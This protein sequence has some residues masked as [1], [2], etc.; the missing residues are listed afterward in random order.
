MGYPKKST[1]T[2]P[3][4]DQLEE[5]FTFGQSPIE[6]KSKPAPKGVVAKMDDYSDSG[7]FVA[8]DLPDGE[9]S[10]DKITARTKAQGAAFVKNYAS[11]SMGPGD[12]VP[13]RVPK[14]TPAVVKQY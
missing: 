14:P 8:V 6:N 13:P 12:A 2:G 7:Q 10:V 9:W 3:M 1:S 5:P 11:T 4:S